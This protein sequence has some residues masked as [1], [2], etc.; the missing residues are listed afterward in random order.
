MTTSHGSGG[1]P[2]N[3]THEP[4]NCHVFRPAEIVSVSGRPGLNRREASSTPASGVKVPPPSRRPRKSHKETRQ[5]DDGIQT[6]Y[7]SFYR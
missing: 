6:K 7:S 1:E 5:T 2:A 4:G 3:N